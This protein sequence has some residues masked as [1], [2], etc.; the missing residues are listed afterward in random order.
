MSSKTARPNPPQ[1]LFTELYRLKA[2]IRIGVYVPLIG[3]ALLLYFVMGLRPA[4]LAVTMGAFTFLATIV[5]EM[6]FVQSRRMRKRVAYPNALAMELGAVSDL[7]EAADVSLRIIAGWLGARAGIIAWRDENHGIVPVA[8]YGLAV[9]SAMRLRPP[10]DEDCPMIAKLLRD[11]RA[12]IGAPA[13][14]SCWGDAFKGAEDI[15]PYV[16]L[17]SRNRVAGIMFLAGPRKS[18]DLSDAKLLESIGIVIGLTLENIRLTSREYESIM[19]VLCSALDMQDSAT[20]GHS[21][22]VARMAALVA[23]QMGLPRADVKCIE[24]AGALHDI[25]KIGVADA[26]LAKPGPL[27]EDEWTEMRRHP[28]LGYE[29]VTGIGSLRRAAEIIYSHHERY[30]GKGYP[31]GLAGDRIPI[32]ARIF[33]VVDSYDAMT[34][35]R[36]YRRAR[37]HQEAIQEIVRNSGKQFDPVAVKAF[38]EVERMG[39][40][41]PHDLPSPDGVREDAMLFDDRRVYR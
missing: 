16:P 12:V 40:I 19:Q 21:Q 13:D 28:R 14:C 25:G 11:Q 41:R 15:A 27:T 33:A 22:R 9:D 20:E 38:L 1:H 36:P 39:H 8:S 5:I 34:S 10:P 18:T 7:F 23:Q 24:Q 17:M 6:A 4:Q 29:I 37:S 35:N 32:G 30:D 3:M 31:R 26:V 2:V